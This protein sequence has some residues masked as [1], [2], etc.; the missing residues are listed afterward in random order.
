[1]MKFA[2]WLAL[3][4]A[5]LAPSIAW[6]VTLQQYEFRAPA[7]VNG[8][9]VLLPGATVTVYLN[10]TTTHA[11]LYDKVT[12]SPISNPMIADASGIV[13]FQAD[14]SA[15]YQLVWSTGIYTSPA[16]PYAGTPPTC[17]FG[18]VGNPC[19]P[20]DLV[21]NAPNGG[22]T[23]AT[24]SV[25][26]IFNLGTAQY[27]QGLLINTQFVDG[28]SSA[29]TVTSPNYNGGALYV[30]SPFGSPSTIVASISGVNLTLVSGTFAGY[31]QYLTDA[32][33]IVLPGT[34]VV[35]GS[36][37]SWIVSRSQTVA[38]ESMTAT[39]YIPHTHIDANGSIWSLA[40]EI[41]SGNLSNTG[42]IL[43]P[44]NF[45][46]AVDLSMLAIWP[47]VPLAIQAKSNGYANYLSLLNSWWLLYEYA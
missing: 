19:A 5:V 18:M 26:E 46:G 7:Q 11:T 10:G 8:A 2:R 17:A 28:Q 42:A 30:N 39:T 35:S 34:Y 1:M 33:N 38:Q 41:L 14:S 24:R 45:S 3:A 37:S 47:D 23:Y 20:I 12:G 44:R 32:G 36:G 27:D 31:G 6:A 4:C 29:I 40:F 22:G 16:T 9:Y 13:A 21:F 25:A 43:Q 15:S